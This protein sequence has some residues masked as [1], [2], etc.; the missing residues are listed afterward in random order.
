MFL[1]HPFYLGSTVLVRATSNRWMSN[2]SPRV[3]YPRLLVHCII[4]LA[5]EAIGA[6]YLLCIH[7]FFQICMIKIAHVFFPF[8][9]HKKLSKNHEVGR[10]W[11]A[12]KPMNSILEG[13]PFLCVLCSNNL[14]LSLELL[15]YQFFGIKIVT[16]KSMLMIDQGVVMRPVSHLPLFQV[17]N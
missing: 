7:I 3:E 6:Y 15:S 8:W 14:L 13:T 9:R 2:P 17:S 10:H 11:P 4:F 5:N 16:W 1:P 12:S